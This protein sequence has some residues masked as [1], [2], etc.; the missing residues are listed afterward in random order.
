MATNGVENRPTM[1]CGHCHG[2]GQDSM[3]PGKDISRGGAFGDEVDTG[4][5]EQG[6]CRYCDGFGKVLLNG[7]SLLFD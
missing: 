1:T 7:R 6:Q 4:R 2:S 3:N 5:Q